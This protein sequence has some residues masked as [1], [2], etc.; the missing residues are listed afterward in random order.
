MDNDNNTL[1]EIRD[2]VT[3]FVLFVGTSK[4][5]DEWLDNPDHT[6]YYE[7]VEVRR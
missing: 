6:E 3:Y 2:A 1:Y 4:E 5:V 7:I